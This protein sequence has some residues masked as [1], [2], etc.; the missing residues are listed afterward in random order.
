M[1]SLRTRIVPALMVL[2][3]VSSPVVLA[4]APVKEAP[5]VAGAPK[6]FNPPARTELKLDN[7]LQVSMVP[8]GDMPMVTIRL[9]VDTGNIHEKTN[10]TWLA[11]LMGR[12][13]PEGTTTRSAE[14]IAQAAAL[15]GGSLN[16]STRQDQ[17]AIGMEVLSES[18]PEAVALVADVAMNPT[19]APAQ[20]ERLKGDLLRDMAI[21]KSQPQVLADEKLAQ[22]LYGDHPYG[23]TFPTEAMLKG[24][25][26]EL[27]RAFYDANVGAARSR[28][29]IVG[30]F[31]AAAVE[32]AVRD[33]FSGWKAGAARVRNVPKQK[34]AKTVQFIDRPGA[35]QSTVRVAV[36]AVSPTSPD[37]IQQRVMNVLLGG[38]FSSRI[39][40]NI[41]EKRGYSYSPI[42]MVTLH[43]DDAFWVQRADVT[44]AVTGESLKE[45]LGEV[46]SLRKTPPPADELRSVQNY[47]AGTFLLENASREGIINQ[48]AFVDLHGLSD[49]YI[50]D[51]VQAVMAVTPEQVQQAAAKTLVRDSMTFVV[52]G[53]LKTVKPQLKVVT[54]ALR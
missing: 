3:L 12:L 50:R 32:K 34:V 18:A 45:I 13:L 37:Y 19:F 5:P 10:E 2:G 46:E 42:S 48:L 20:V 49:A 9:M 33:A 17:S 52:V 11:D 1:N 39:T 23:R 27:V 21:Y 40:A 29:Y 14:Q 38:Y 35:V 41:R 25:T 31:D 24:Y 8:Y 22:S 6:P 30:R 36:K 43:P 53:D 54:P 4:Q 16:V 51:Y 44:T 15:L 47:L 7:G 26:P 28:L